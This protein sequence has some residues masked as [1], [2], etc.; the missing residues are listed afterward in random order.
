[1]N[2]KWKFWE[3]KFVQ[4]IE[5]KHKAGSFLFATTL[6]KLRIVAIQRVNGHTEIVFRDKENMPVTCRFYYDLI[7]LQH[8][9]FVLKISKEIPNIVIKGDIEFEP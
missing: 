6:N 9:E 4:P 8:E 2:C 3:P 5:L 1:M 7:D